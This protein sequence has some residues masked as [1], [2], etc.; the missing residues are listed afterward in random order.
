MGDMGLI[1][2]HLNIVEFQ[3]IHI[4]YC[5]CRFYNQN[6]VLNYKIFSFYYI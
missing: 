1:Y 6:Y 4:S 5:N 3:V 2:V